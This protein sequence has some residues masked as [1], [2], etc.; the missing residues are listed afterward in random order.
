MACVFQVFAV[1][2]RPVLQGGL[3][4]YLCLMQGEFALDLLVQGVVFA[5][6]GLQLDGKPFQIIQVS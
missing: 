6:A 1:G 5:K 3:N 4:G 2:N